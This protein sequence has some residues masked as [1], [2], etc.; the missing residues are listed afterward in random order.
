M[1]RIAKIKLLMKTMLCA[2]FIAMFAVSDVWAVSYT[3][4]L[5][6]DERNCR[7]KVRLETSLKKLKEMNLNG[8]VE[9]TQKRDQMVAEL[10]TV[11]SACETLKD[12]FPD[13][14][15]KLQK[16]K[17]VDNPFW[18][19]DVE[20]T[21]A[22]YKDL[23][24]ERLGQV[25]DQQTAQELLSKYN[26]ANANMTK[27][28][29]DYFSDYSQ[30]VEEG[31]FTCG[32]SYPYGCP[33]GQKC[34]KSILSDAGSLTMGNASINTQFDYTC[35][36]EKP[37]FN[38]FTKKAWQEAPEGSQGKGFESYTT[39]IGI[40]KGTVTKSDGSGES[41]TE[42]VGIKTQHF[43]AQATGETFNYPARSNHGFCE[44]PQM[45]EDYTGT[46][47]SC[48]IVSSLIRTFM[49]VAVKAFPV[50]QEAGVKLLVIGMVL[51]SAFFVLQKLSSFAS[52]EPMKVLQELFIF[53]FKCLIAYTLVTSGISVINKLIVNPILIAGSEYGSA[54][55]DSVASEAKMPTIAGKAVEEDSR[56]YVLNNTGMIDQEVFKN[57]MRISKKADAAVSVN[58][59]IGEAVACHAFHAGAIQF[60]VGSNDSLINFYF[61]D[62]WIWLCGIVIWCFA[63]MLVMGVNFYLLDLS[64][65]IGFAMLALPVTIGLWPFNKFK[66]KFKIC[67]D[68]ILNAFGTFLFLGVTTGMSIML[69]S[70]ALGGTSDLFDAIANDKKEYISRVFGLTSGA[71][72]LILFAFIYSQKLISET[73]SKL[74]DKFFPAKTSGLSPIHSHTTQAIDFAKK[75]IGNG[76]SMLTSGVTGGASA[77]IDASVKKVARTAIS[78]AR[79]GWR[80]IRNKFSGKK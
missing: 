53:L 29:R 63:F 13:V 27:I 17:K 74:A 8:N 24:T 5:T 21:D 41:K 55:I 37:K 26:E 28:S 71:F 10:Q 77:A 67:I 65:K 73:V 14:M 64:F 3:G 59:V 32:S 66:D 58:F 22:E 52:L 70:G 12:T 61:P 54:I 23:M 51:W 38:A 56:N 18:E 7:N 43:Q 75:Q 25:E 31:G 35:S 36:A 44:I 30:Y 62:I 80:S 9:A 46:C 40:Q 60:T 78:K 49:D 72:L 16:E 34:W 76:V 11:I 39:A 47:Y 20:Y 42:I 33:E 48:L 50:A 6:E 45:M 68:I 19:A 15:K 79:G 57:I 4:F 2:T 69:I 1:C